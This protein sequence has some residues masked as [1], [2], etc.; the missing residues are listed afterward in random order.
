FAPQPTTS[1]KGTTLTVLCGRERRARLAGPRRWLGRPLVAPDRERDENEKDGRAPGQRLKHIRSCRSPEDESARRGGGNGDRLVLGEEPEPTGHRVDGDECRGGENERSHDRKGGSLGG[2]GIAD[3]EPD[4]GENP[5]EDVTEEQHQR[6]RSQELEQAGVHPESDCEADRGHERHDEDVARQVCG[7][8]A[9]EDSGARHR[10]RAKALQEAGIE[11][12][13]EANGGAHSAEDHGLDKD[14]R[15]QEVYIAITGYPDGAAENV[16]EEENE[17]DRLDGG[18][19]EQLRYAPVPEKIALHYR[20]Y[21]GRGAGQAA[22]AVMLTRG[23]GSSVHGHEAPRAVTVSLSAMVTGAARLP[24]SVRNA[25]SRL[26][27]RTARETGI[28]SSASRARRASTK[29][30]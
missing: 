20:E 13:G 3:D 19:D 21:V 28:T 1:G 12:G 23:Q 30:R 17:D 8:P 22:E 5:A 10:Q 27:S 11:V 29:T 16:S 24:V 4:S 18:E 25:S 7:R 2:L 9:G 14:A 15:H 6:E 26:G